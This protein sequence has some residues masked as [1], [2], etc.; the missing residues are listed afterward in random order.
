MFSI[1]LLGKDQDGDST[2]KLFVIPSHKFLTEAIIKEDLHST[3][4]R[5]EI[6]RIPIKNGELDI[7]L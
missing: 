7:P 4:I 5:K 2:G 1:G 6:L 3:G